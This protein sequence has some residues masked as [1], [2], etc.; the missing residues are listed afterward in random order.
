MIFRDLIQPKEFYDGQLVWFNISKTTNKISI[1]HTVDDHPVYW[2]QSNSYDYVGICC[3]QSRNK[4]TVRNL[5]FYK[6]LISNRLPRM[7]PYSLSKLPAKI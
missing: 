2:N 4:Q 7:Y 6:D 5:L 3:L 1:L